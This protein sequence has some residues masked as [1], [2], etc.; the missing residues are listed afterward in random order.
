MN[1][2]HIGF[3]FLL[4]NT[5]LF[6]FCDTGYILCLYAVC[7][8]HEAGHLIAARLLGVKI[9]RIVF[10]GIGIRITTEKNAASPILRDAAVVLSGPAANLVMCMCLILSGHSGETAALELAAAVYNLLPFYQLD[11]GTLLDILVTGTVR[12]R[13]WRRCISAA[14]LFAA[15]LI[16]AALVYSIGQ[17]IAVPGILHVWISI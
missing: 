9:R 12:E 15:V 13:M 1:I 3:S 16:L 10:T 7:A 14:Q 17:S 4:L 11:G 5:L 6:A 2:I 8:I